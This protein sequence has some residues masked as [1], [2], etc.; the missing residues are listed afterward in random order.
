MVHN[1]SLLVVSLRWPPF[2][3]S[4]GLYLGYLDKFD[5]CYPLPAA[6]EVIWVIIAFVFNSVGLLALIGSANLVVIICFDF[7]VA[8][9]YT[10]VNALKFGLFYL[11]YPTHPTPL[12]LCLF[13]F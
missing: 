2:V 6:E 8:F 10:I 7:K 3:S 13:F 9:F 5:L 11:L 12:S 1:A 4:K